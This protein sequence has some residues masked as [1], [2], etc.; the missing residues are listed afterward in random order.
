M[1]NLK[2]LISAIVLF[3]SVN[4]YGQTI[5]HKKKVKIQD[6]LIVSGN[7][8]TTGTLSGTS[9]SFNS[10]TTKGMT[11]DV[12]S[13]PS[14]KFL[15]NV[16]VAGQLAL[17][18]P[19][20][21]WAD[22]SVHS[23]T[24]NVYGNANNRLFLVDAVNSNVSVDNATLTFLEGVHRSVISH[25]GQTGDI[26]LSLPPTSGTLAL[27][28]ALNSYLPLTGGTLTGDLIV[29]TKVGIETDDPRNKLDIAL[30]GS[31]MV[32]P[33]STGTSPTG[34]LRIGHTDT[35]WTGVELNMG[36]A[37]AS[38]QGYPA[39]IQAQNPADLSVSRNI[40]IN[41]NGGSVAIGTISLDTD[42]KL[43]VNGNILASSIL[44]QSNNVQTIT[45]STSAATIGAN[46]NVVVVD[47]SVS[48]TLTIATTTNIAS[49]RVINISSSP[50]YFSAGTSV[51]VDDNGG[52][53]SY[54][55][56]QPYASATLI[57]IAANSWIISE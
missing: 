18:D 27:T 52:R 20:L 5:V 57:K 28:T 49:I 26:A 34:G 37:N 17:G 32:Y 21:S 47:T 19:L 3:L 41:P 12:I 44:P 36:I 35:S 38:A 45:G 14:V 56:G 53:L 24:L 30:I 55:S 11:L 1:R 2:L 46:I 54:S 25:G 6:S 50:V 23:N 22:V 16:D 31:E 48:C 13:P 43:E 9:A 4:T 10:V 33:I 39:W 40:L 29:D 8:K 15:P 42:S 51:T 7:I